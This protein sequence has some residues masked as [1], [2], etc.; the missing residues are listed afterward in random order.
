MAVGEYEVL[1]GW[2][3]PRAGLVVGAADRV[4]ESLKRAQF[5]EL[6]RGEPCESY[7]FASCIDIWV[8][9]LT[10]ARDRSAASQ[11]RSEYAERKRE[12]VR[13]YRIYTTLDREMAEPSAVKIHEEKKISGKTLAKATRT[14]DWAPV[15]LIGCLV[16]DSE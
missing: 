10:V 13:G 4:K 8:D 16:T 2:L 3:V 11:F 15:N 14:L 5:W 1:V 9:Y 7:L 6:G 12:Q